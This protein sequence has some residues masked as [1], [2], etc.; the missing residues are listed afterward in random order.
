MTVCVLVRVSQNGTEK[1]IKCVEGYLKV[2][3]DSRGKLFFGKAS[4]VWNNVS[5]F[6]DWVKIYY[7]EK[8]HHVILFVKN[9]IKAEKSTL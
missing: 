8:T 2:L 7:R 1:L 4:A 9:N 5:N 6:Q 3:Q